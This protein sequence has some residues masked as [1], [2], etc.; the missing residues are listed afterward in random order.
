MKLPVGQSVGWSVNR[1]NIGGIS[2]A[3][4]HSHEKA[5]ST[6]TVVPTL[7]NLPPS[8]HH[9]SLQRAQT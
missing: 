4:S 6:I 1:A 5:E 9:L 2:N 7:S 3:L 8:W